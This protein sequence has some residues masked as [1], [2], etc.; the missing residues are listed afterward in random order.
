MLFRL[1]ARIALL[2]F[3]SGELRPGTVLFLTV[4]VY[5]IRECSKLRAFQ[6][7][8]LKECCR[9]G[10][11]LLYQLLS[12]ICQMTRKLVHVR[13]TCRSVRWMHRQQIH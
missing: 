12:F 4:T 6:S 11:K 5:P 3:I 8:H 2:V 13:L 9:K 1:S 7:Q 10:G